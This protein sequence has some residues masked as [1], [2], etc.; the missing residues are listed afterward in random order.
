MKQTTKN[1]LAAFILPFILYLGCS[2]DAGTINI[3]KHQAPIL[4]AIVFAILVFIFLFIF[5]FDDFNKYKN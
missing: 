3:L 1:I 2:L 5:E 4:E